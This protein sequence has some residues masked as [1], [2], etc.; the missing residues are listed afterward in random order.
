MKKHNSKLGHDFLKLNTRVFQIIHAES[1]NYFQTSE[2]T[3]NNK[4]DYVRPHIDQQVYPS[5]IIRLIHSI[6][7]WKLHHTSESF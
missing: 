3:S 4:Y 5:D 7:G 6:D 2:V 1:T